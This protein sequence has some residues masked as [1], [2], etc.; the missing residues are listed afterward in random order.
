MVYFVWK[1]NNKIHSFLACL[2]FFSNTFWINWSRWLNWIGSILTILIC[3]M[4]LNFGGICGI[5]RN[6]SSKYYTIFSESTISERF[7]AYRRLCLTLVFRRYQLS[8][9]TILLFRNNIF[10][11]FWHLLNIL[12]DSISHY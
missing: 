6:H 12:F 9:S 11:G 5:Q 8:K 3:T 4:L 10:C 1:N 2:I 7:I